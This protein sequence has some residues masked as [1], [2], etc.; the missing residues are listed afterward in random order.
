MFAPPLSNINS[1]IVPDLDMALITNN[2]E[3]PECE[4]SGSLSRRDVQSV[5]C[6]RCRSEHALRLSNQLFNCDFRRQL[7][8][9][10][11]ATQKLT[12]GGLESE[13]CS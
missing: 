10:E 11:G 4:F 3:T 5:H 7:R 1:K 8:E 12:T 13:I 2:F 6:D 9:A